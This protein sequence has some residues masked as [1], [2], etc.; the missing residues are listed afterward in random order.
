MDTDIEKGVQE[1]VQHH[2]VQQEVMWKDDAN[3]RVAKGV[4]EKHKNNIAK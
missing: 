4:K 3:F 2:P 1:R